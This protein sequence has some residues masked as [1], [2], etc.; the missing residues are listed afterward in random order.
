MAIV[1]DWVDVF[2]ITSFRDVA[3]DDY[4]AA[5]AAY[6]LELNEPFLWLALQAVEK[7]LKAVLILNRRSTIGL[8][9]D[10]TKA[11]QHL[12]GIP[13][14]PFNF[15]PDIA[16]FIEYV[17]EEGPNRY[18]GYPS[19]LHSDA[20]IGLDRTVW[21]LRRYC[22]SVRRD[23]RP[24]FAKTVAELKM[25]PVTAK[26]RFAIK[27]GRLEQILAGKTL[28]RRHLVWKNFWY[29]SRRRR[30]IANFPQRWQWSQP[31]HFMQPGVYCALKDLVQF[32]AAVRAHFE[33]GAAAGKKKGT[34]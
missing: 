16:K 6:R 17:N 23:D 18:R 27:G 21:H 4:V 32:E 30:R 8:N 29:G 26:S 31:V 9:H 28:A 12:I 7:Y 25:D 3:D 19:V 20:L 33:P 2:V 22:Q 24:G 5:R 15:P 10:V 1:D 14:L 13:D 11:F 34:A